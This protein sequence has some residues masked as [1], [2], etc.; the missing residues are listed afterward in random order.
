MPPHPQGSRADQ[1]KAIWGWAL[2][3]WANSA[4]AT[5]V[6]A[7]FFPAFFKEFWSRGIDVNLTTARLGVGYALASLT[8]AVMA[9][10]IG[11]VADRGARRKRF[12]IALTG[13]GVVSTAALALVP[14]G[15]W[16]AALVTYAAAAIGFSGAIA[17]YDAFLPLV[18]PPSR[19]DQVSSLG[20]AL[21]YLGGGLLFV[22]NV[23]MTLKPHL[24]GLADGSQA[25]RLSFVSV[26]VW[27]GGFGAWSFI[28]MPS[29]PAGVPASL[30]THA[31]Q[32]F[33]Q[34]R[35]T[36]GRIRHYRPAFIFLLAYWCYIDGVDTIIKMA[37]DYGISLGLQFNDLIVALLITQFIGFPAALAFG[38][39]GRRW[40][41]RPGIYLALAIY[42]AVT[43]YGAMLERTVEFF[44][45]AAAIGLVQGGIQALSRSY[46]ARLIPAGQ[47]AE[48]F[49]FYNML[50]KFAA[51]VGPAL[52]GIT[53]L[54][55]KRTLLPPAPSPEQV[56]AIGL[57]ATR[58]SIIS[59]LLLFIAG[60]VLL[61]FVPAESAGAEPFFNRSPGEPERHNGAR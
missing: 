40:G 55:V 12:L 23:L 59:V 54:M 21:G 19:F 57:L 30:W 42:M 8:L 27:W 4:F 14:Q 56:H 17:L 3:D 49:G 9:P 36:F 32:G 35:A 61:Y 25:V 53:G 18:A 7:A 38:L 5:T 58:T 24:F 45:L 39:L 2:Y 20:Y 11:A 44:I 16:P 15:A 6:M 47:S 43:I 46:F 34:L 33:A 1:R 60:A 10:V 41:A 26:A 13:L 50:G 31:R 48:F 22:F 52:M 37:M 29:E 28:W 51:I